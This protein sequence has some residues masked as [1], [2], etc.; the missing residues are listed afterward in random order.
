MQ[1]CPW[2]WTRDFDRL[3]GRADVRDV[4]DDKRIGDIPVDGRED[5]ED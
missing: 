1:I 3:G 5:A 4:T 2:R